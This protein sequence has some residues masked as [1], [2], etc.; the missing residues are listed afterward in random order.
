MNIIK[1]TIWTLCGFQ[2]IYED[3]KERFYKDHEYITVVEINIEMSQKF[4][5]WDNFISATQF[6]HGIRPFLENQLGSIL[7]MDVV[8]KARQKKPLKFV[9]KKI[10]RKKK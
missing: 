3:M 8:L 9:I 5:N 6:V 2:K 10:V 7:G 4:Y 1:G